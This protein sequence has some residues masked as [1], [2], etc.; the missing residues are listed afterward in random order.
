MKICVVSLCCEL[1]LLQSGHCDKVYRFICY[2]HFTVFLSNILQAMFF[3]KGGK[4]RP[5]YSDG[6][7]SSGNF[8]TLPNQQK[9]WEFVFYFKVLYSSPPLTRNPKGN[10]KLFE[11]AAV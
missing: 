8:V 6:V 2:I 11:L 3:K 5:C 7:I 10:E 9:R 4:T 1:L